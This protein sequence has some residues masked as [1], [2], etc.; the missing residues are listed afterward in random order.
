MSEELSIRRFIV[1][2]ADWASEKNT[3]SNIRRI[4]F[5]VEQGVPRDEEWDGRDEESCHFIAV[6]EDDRP[7]GTARL[8]PEG[9]IG[10][11]A[12]VSEYRRKGVGRVLLEA[13]VEKARHL[14]FERVFLHA[15]THALSFYEGCGFKPFGDEFEEAGI[16]H[17]EMEMALK[18][19]EDKVQR[20]TAVA[21]SLD[22]G[23]KQFD[24]REVSWADY[25]PRIR[26]IRRSVLVGELG[27]PGEFVEDDA[28]ADAIH[29]IAEDEQSGQAIGSVRMSVDGAAARLTV[30]PEHRG[31]GIGKSLLEL[32]V[33]K[34]RRF[35]LRSVKVD[36]LAELEPLYL[37]AGFEPRGESFS[38]YDHM[39]QS[40]ECSVD[41]PGT[42]D[43]PMRQIESDRFD[44]D[45]VI[46]RLGEDKK[47]I[48]LRSEDDFHN[49]IIEMCRQATQS[50]RIY[51][52]VLEHKL[53]DEPQLRDICSALARRNKYTL[54]EMLLYDS[55]RVVKNG[56]CL[57]EIAR[58]LP[59]SIRIRVVHPELRQQNHEYVLA[60]SAG[61]IYRHD[62]E[63]YDGYANFSDIADGN[64]LARQFARAW[65][66]SLHDPYL[67]TLKI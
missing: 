45:D 3:L 65:D 52:P 8:L 16:A 31:K 39:H 50:I 49:I 36:A 43:I 48:L 10:R 44:N 14:G 51:S 66:S 64:R 5:I 13:A 59:S 26:V 12:V 63:V 35:G 57:L 60:D 19:L 38:A 23:V 54:V 7:I 62:N 28:D 21:T 37:V 40:F 25:R 47:L 33:A 34:A 17:R 22:I 9:Q 58:R 41:P 29:W 6:S 4:V 20:K 42:D 46:Y 30:L 15:Q 2:D 27:L 55:H 32:T 61:V 18:P 67:R 53:F 56:H 11:M 24:T 1:R